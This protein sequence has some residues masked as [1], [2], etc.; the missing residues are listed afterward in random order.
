ML[1]SIQTNHVISKVIIFK[2]WIFQRKNFVKEE[3]EAFW[4]I[5]EYSSFLT[6]NQSSLT[7]LKNNII[8]RNVEVLNE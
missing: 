7:L 3:R 4:D 6:W 8:C 2:K 1:L 5:D